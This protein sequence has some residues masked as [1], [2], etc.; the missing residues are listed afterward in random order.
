MPSFLLF[1]FTSLQLHGKRRPTAAAPKPYGSLVCRI[2]IKTYNPREHTP[3]GAGIDPS[4]GFDAAFLQYHGFLPF[5]EHLEHLNC[6]LQPSPPGCF[7][8]KLSEARGNGIGVVLLVWL[9][10]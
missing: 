2:A 7:T 10:A 4:E 6:S 9:K 1:T 3:R 8:E 5:L